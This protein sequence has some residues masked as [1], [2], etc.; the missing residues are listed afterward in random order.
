MHGDPD[1]V[2]T[3][4]STGSPTWRI[5]S[6][7]SPDRGRRVGD[8]ALRLWA[9]ALA[10]ADYERFVLPAQPQGVRRPSPTSACRA[11]TSASTPASCSALMADAGAD[12]VGVDWRVPL[13]DARAPASAPTWR[14]RATSTRPSC[15]APWPV[16]GRRAPAT[17]CAATPA[18]RATSSTSATAC[19]PTPTPACS[20][21][22][23]ELVHAEGRADG[24]ASA[25]DGAA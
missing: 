22:V 7:R 9:G 24:T 6:L 19:C 25:A 15:L 10:P 4:S 5:A 20:S 12:V 23:V 3:S 17:C 14:C 8:P 2:G 13:D 18:T 1:A 11:S 21:E 16:V